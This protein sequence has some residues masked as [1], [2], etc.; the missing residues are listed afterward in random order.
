MTDWGGQTTPHAAEGPQ[1]VSAAEAADAAGVTPGTV[2]YWAR[3][4]LIVS[5]V[6]QG[7]AGE[8]TLVRLDEVLQHARQETPGGR[9]PGGPP[10][11][12]EVVTDLPARTS[13]LAPILKSIPEIMSQLTAATDRA[14]R[15]ETKVEFLSA[16]LAEL[17]KRLADAEAVAPSDAFV[18]AAWETAGGEIETPASAPETGDSGGTFDL[19]AATS[20]APAEPGLDWGSTATSGEPA[21]P[22]IDWAGTAAGDDTAAPD[23]S[24]AAET[25][26]SLAEVWADPAPGESARSSAPPPPGDATRAPSQAPWGDSPDDIQWHEPAVGGEAPAEPEPETGPAPPRRANA[27]IPEDGFYGPRRRRWFKRRR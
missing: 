11:G 25:P 23:P 1:W 14:A 18:P 21:E 15:A 2:R 10:P 7:P 27:D 17:R 22:G 3:N 24:P 26:L 12:E 6:V 4:G 16:Q 20:D 13:E 5:E 19:G 8:R 9:G